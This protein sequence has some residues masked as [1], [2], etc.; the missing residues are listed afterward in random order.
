MRLLRPSMM[1]AL[2]MISSIRAESPAPVTLTSLIAE[3]TDGTSVAKWPDPAFTCLQ[4]SS[5]DRRTVA[6]DRDGWFANDDHTQFIRDEVTEGRK[7]RVMMDADGPGSIVRFWLTTVKNKHGVI[8]IYLDGAAAPALTFPAYDLMSGTLGLKEPMVI[9]HPGYTAVELRLECTLRLHSL[10]PRGTSGERVGERGNP[11]KPSSSPRPS[12][13]PSSEEREKSATVSDADINSKAVPF[14]GPALSKVVHADHAQDFVQR[15]LSVDY[16]P[17]THLPQVLH[18][19][20]HGD[21]LESPGRRPFQNRI[22]QHLVNHQH[23]CDRR[24]SGITRPGAFVA[25]RAPSERR[26]YPGHRKT[27]RLDG[28][29]GWW[30]AGGGANPL[31]HRNRTDR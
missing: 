27:E 25:T 9:P 4:A 2:A 23:F 31:C 17:Q 12:P 21:L 20:L 14:S 8:R 18:P 6:P 30:I 3:M 13:P 5:Y 19:L 7:E 22:A 16:A 29:A 10:A 24:S 28:G 11:I 1:I 26:R 15:C